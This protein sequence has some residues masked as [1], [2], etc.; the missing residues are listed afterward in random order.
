MG[1]T[2]MGYPASWISGGW[3][4][5][6]GSPAL[7]KFHKVYISRLLIDRLKLS[8]Q[9]NH[10]G[11][12]G[13]CFGLTHKRTP[14]CPENDNF[15]IIVGDD[16]SKRQRP[17]EVRLG[18]HTCASSQML[19][20]M[21][22]MKGRTRQGMNSGTMSGAGDWVYVVMPPGR[23]VASLDLGGQQR[24]LGLR[25]EQ[26]AQELC[27]EPYFEGNNNSMVVA[28]REVSRRMSAESNS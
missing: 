15:E 6:K 2:T 16:H 14:R 28:C 25:L 5:D 21:R 4:L 13:D 3:T 10:I 20:E 19:A 9:S 8:F 27:Q 26:R 22:N 11:P 18:G 17:N 1:S 23:L 24:D 7:S 12:T